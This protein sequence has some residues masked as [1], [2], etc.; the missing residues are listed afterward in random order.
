MEIQNAAPTFF[1]SRENLDGVTN[2]SQLSIHFGT[3]LK[4]NSEPI[5]DNENNDIVAVGEFIYNVIDFHLH[6]D[7][8]YELI[9]SED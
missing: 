2:K 3:I 9:L 8:Y 5:L 1:S 4:E 6:A 7:N